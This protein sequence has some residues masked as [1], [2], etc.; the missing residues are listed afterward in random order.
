MTVAAPPESALLPADTVAG[1]GV[2]SVH[3]TGSPA[4]ALRSAPATAPPVESVVSRAVTVDVA[5]GPVSVAGPAWAA[6][7]SRGEVVAEPATVSQP[8]VP[9]PPLQPNQFSAA[10]TLAVGPTRSAEPEPAVLPVT[11]LCRSVAVPAYTSIAPPDGD[12]PPV[13][14]LP[15]NVE[16]LTAREPPS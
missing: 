3:E 10:S 12:V 16:R 8:A 1:L 5:P 14:E 2:G 6:S 7:T 9:G 4:N 15:V 11:R 13:T